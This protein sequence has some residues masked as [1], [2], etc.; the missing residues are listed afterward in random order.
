MNTKTYLAIAAYAAT[1]PLANWMI[2]NVG[3]C[4]PN[5]PCLIPVGFGLMAPSGVLIVGLALALRDVVQEMAGVKGALI[6]IAIGGVLS[7]LFASPYLVVASVAAFLLSELADLL[8]YTPLRKNRLYLAVLLSGL[9][10]AIV[11]SAAFLLIA[12]RSLDFIAGQV[13]GKLWMSITALPVLWVIRNRC[14]IGSHDWRL[15]R[16]YGYGFTEKCHRC[17]EVRDS[18]CGD[19]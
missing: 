13:V 2:G 10:G 8:V 7:W 15:L 3:T 18:G 5:G 4:V 6:A 17:G 1:I 19:R 16:D 12:F 11:D 14:N 9:V